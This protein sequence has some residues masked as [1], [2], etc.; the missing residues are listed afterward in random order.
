[1]RSNTGKGKKP[2]RVWLHESPILCL[3]SRS[4]WEYK[5]TSELV[6]LR[7]VGCSFTLL[8]PSVTDSSSSRAM[9]WKKT[10]GASTYKGCTQKL[11]MSTE[12]SKGLC[13]VPTASSTTTGS[14]EGLKA[15]LSQ[16]WAHLIF[17]TFQNPESGKSVSVAWAHCAKTTTPATGIGQWWNSAKLDQSS[18][19]GTLLSQQEYLLPLSLKIQ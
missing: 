8:H 19:S 4:A 16:I 11:G 13:R 17:P 15:W 6:W 10:A 12:H 5:L 9:C 2:N 3:I 18:Y 1:M 7:Q 14:K